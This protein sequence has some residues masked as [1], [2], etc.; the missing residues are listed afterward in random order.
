[1]Q[2]VKMRIPYSGFLAAGCLLLFIFSGQISF[3]QSSAPIEWTRPNLLWPDTSWK[4]QGGIAKPEWFDK[5][6]DDH[7]WQT[8]NQAFLYLA[9]DNKSWMGIGS[10]RKSFDVPDSLRGKKLELMIDQLGAS[11]IYFDGKRV[12]EFGHVADNAKE[13]RT[14]IV[15]VPHHPV[16]ID[17]DSQSSHVLSIYYSNH[18]PESLSRKIGI[19]GFDVLL[20]PFELGAKET[21]SSFP[22]N[23]V[24]V[25]MIL[26]FCLFF[27]FVYGFYP[28]RLASLMSAIFLAVFSLLFIGNIINDFA[29]DIRSLIL[30]TSFWR[31]SFSCQAGL[32]LLF[33]YSLYYGRMPKR[34]WIVLALI[35]IAAVYGIIAAEY[36]FPVITPMIVLFQIDT[37]RILIL[38]IRKKRTG[39][40]ILAI[41]MIISILVVLFAVFNLFHFFPWYMTNTQAFFSVFTD[42]TFPLTLALQFA[43]EFGSANRDLRRQLVQVNELSEKNLEQERE[44]QQILSSQNVTLEKQVSERTSQVVAQNKEIEKQRDQ[45]TQT[46]EELKATQKQLIQSEKMASLGEL[47]AGIAHEIQNPLNFVNN[48]SEVNQELIDEMKDEVG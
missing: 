36:P 21:N 27:L 39:F 10:F 25:F 26:G 24:S 11:A 45:V 19:R 42:L 4:Y 13:E 46:L 40:W 22:H 47:T 15:F 3:A 44:K 48:F 17:L 1:M 2:F 5:Q 7:Q 33:L 12:A 31:I 37:W 16:Q 29:T 20:S 8:V 9:S 34:S 6:F 18:T 35:I 23:F 28:Y 32:Y 14:R 43:L 30:G 41:G 38:G